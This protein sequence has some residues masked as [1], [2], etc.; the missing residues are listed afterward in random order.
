MR[1][2]EV[3]DEMSDDGG[4]PRPRSVYPTPIFNKAMST[5]DYAVLDYTALHLPPA[6]LAIGALA[7]VTRLEGDPVMALV[8]GFPLEDIAVA[9]R[10]S[11][12]RR[13]LWLFF[14]L[15]GGLSGAGKN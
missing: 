9:V 6:L 4:G 11:L 1:I 15:G 5:L 7:M 3:I 12:I 13:C 8:S 14:F 2:R 10:P